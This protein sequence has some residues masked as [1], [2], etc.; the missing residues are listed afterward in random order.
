MGQFTDF[1]FFGAT[2]SLLCSFGSPMFPWF[3]VILLALHWCL[4][5]WRGTPLFQTSVLTSEGK[6]LLVQVAAR[7]SLLWAGV[8]C[9]RAPRA[10][11]CGDPRSGEASCVVGSGH[12]F[13]ASKIVWSFRWV[14]GTKGACALSSASRPSGYGPGLV[15]VVGAVMCTCSGVGTGCTCLANAGR[16]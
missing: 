16:Y 9:C 1:H 6:Y 15:V 7:W 3:F 5:I 11:A 8:A 12:Q 4:C 2:E 13:T 14:S 10:V